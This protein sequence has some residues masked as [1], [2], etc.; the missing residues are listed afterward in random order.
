M[1]TTIKRKDTETGLDDLFGYSVDDVEVKKELVVKS[2]PLNDALKWYIS[3]LGKDWD[4]HVRFAKTDLIL[5]QGEINTLLNLTSQ[6]NEYNRYSQNTGFLTSL[7]I[8]NSYDSGNN[9]FFFILPDETEITYFGTY[10][11]ADTNRPLKLNLKGKLGEEFGYHSKNLVVA[12]DGDVGPYFGSYAKNLDATI[13][14]KIDPWSFMWH[15]EESI[16]RL[17]CEKKSNRLFVNLNHSY[18]PPN[19]RN[20]DVV[21]PNSW[22]KDIANKKLFGDY[23]KLMLTKGGKESLFAYFVSK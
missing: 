20:Y 10:L 18:D 22:F 17:D 12:V 8:Q 11:K 23:N 1:I 19:D 13:N 21:F 7:L 15:T 5:T 16:L 9:D 4:D 3:F 6:Y 14:G 2:G